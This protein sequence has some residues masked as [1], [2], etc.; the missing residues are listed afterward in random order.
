MLSSALIAPFLMAGAALG[1][2]PSP[3]SLGVACGMQRNGGA[4]SVGGGMRRRGPAAVAMSSTVPPQ[5]PDVNQNLSGGDFD[6]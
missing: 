2:V 1:F 3:G 6:K 4:R 5:L